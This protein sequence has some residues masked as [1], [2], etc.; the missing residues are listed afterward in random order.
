MSELFGQ[1]VPEMIGLFITPAAVVGCVL[2]LQSGNAVRNAFS[3]G[4]AFLLVYLQIGLAGLLGGA[5]DPH[6]TSTTV[7]H[8]VGFLVGLMFLAIGA[9]LL[10]RHPSRAPGKPQWITE[11]E[12]AGPR[13]AFAAG[14]VL[15][16]LN[17]NL[18]IMLSGISVIAQSG[19]G[20]AVSIFA[21]GLLLLAAA[22]DFLIPIGMY[23][24]MGDR[25]R[26]GL[27]AAKQW[28]V[29]HDRILAVCVFVG[30]GLLF[31][32]RGL[33]ALR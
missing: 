20:P 26:S 1:L 13:R 24:L 4:A 18:F 25:A 5:T 31:T 21:T 14:L 17:P 3:F 23:V 22:L 19:S 15:A 27:G 12:S 33:A 29:E 6:A 8:W 16:V 2:L 7:A 32:G 10:L 9:V 30:F 28:M 11:L